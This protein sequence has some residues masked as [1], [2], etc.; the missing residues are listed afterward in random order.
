MFIQFNDLINPHMVILFLHTYLVI[1]GVK[2][3]RAQ[4]NLGIYNR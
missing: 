3:P 4:G 1:R 2:V